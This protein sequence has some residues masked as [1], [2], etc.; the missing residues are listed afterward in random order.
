ML[1][2]VTVL[3]APA[4]AWAATAKIPWIEYA[5]MVKEIEKGS[6]QP[7]HLAKIDEWLDDQGKD[8]KQGT[9]KQPVCAYQLKLIWF[10]NRYAA[11]TEP[12]AW[13]EDV[14]VAI[15]R[16]RQDGSRCDGYVDTGLVNE[17][18]ARFEPMYARYE[19][20][21]RAKILT[22]ARDD[23]ERR[24]REFADLLPLSGMNCEAGDDVEAFRKDQAIAA[25][26]AL[27]ELRKAW[28]SQGRTGIADALPRLDGIDDP[29]EAFSRLRER[30]DAGVP[31][32]QQLWQERVALRR[33]AIEELP[34]DAKADWS[35]QAA[36][37]TPADLKAW[38]FWG[39]LGKLDAQ[40]AEIRSSGADYER[41]KSALVAEVRSLSPRTSECRALEELC[42]QRS[43]E[44]VC[45]RSAEIRS[46]R[47]TCAD[48]RLDDPSRAGL[49]ALDEVKTARQALAADSRWATVTQA[50]R[51][52]IVAAA[53]RAQGNCASQ[54]EVLQAMQ[55]AVGRA[56]NASLGDVAAFGAA[57]SAITRCEA[58]LAGDYTLLAEAIGRV[59]DRGG[60]CANGLRQHRT[61]LEGTASAITRR[62]AGAR[63][64]SQLA[65]GRVKL[66]SAMEC[67]E[68]DWSDRF[69]QAKSALEARSGIATRARQWIDRVDDVRYGA[70]RARI[71]QAAPSDVPDAF[72]CAWDRDGIAVDP[73]AEID[74]WIACEPVGA[75]GVE[76][77]CRLLLVAAVA[78]AAEDFAAADWSAAASRFDD[79]RN[80]CGESLAG[81]REGEILDYFS[82]YA[83][84]KR[85]AAAVDT[86]DTKVARLGY[87]PEFEQRFASGGQP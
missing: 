86:Q 87:D 40:V 57:K 28:Q 82:T 53:G 77:V 1:A 30:I 14:Q 47:A 6:T 79:V 37:R 61:R 76:D 15:Q 44:A 9:Q 18:I 26:Q 17:A 85:N 46:L 54:T 11:G 78:A 32:R 71:E 74:R 72:R 45:T 62:G 3:L 58:G 55:D 69:A 33:E 66:V 73:G 75:G 21:N 36:P 67:Y 5:N 80:Q 12:D 24:K 22:A 23:C 42:K 34:P 25:R 60:P 13:I 68:S 35:G 29:D 16:T 27:G 4:T 83:A 7:Q 49:A 64:E 65:E 19:Q 43:L 84:W 10:K 41:R 20:A 39:E 31:Q 2:F 8:V 59:E 48:A 38:S 56:R 52:D 51:D 63:Q 50:F 70:V 81:G